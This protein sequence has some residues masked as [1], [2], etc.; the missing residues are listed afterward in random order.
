[1]TADRRGSPLRG[2]HSDRARR[3]SVSFNAGGGR[4]ESI[5]PEALL[6]R[7]LH[8]LVGWGIKAEWAFP[9]R[10]RGTTFGGARAGYS[11]LTS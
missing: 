4:G 11:T 7:G 8:S 6:P 2:Q 5:R 3:L 10:E 9:K 1:M